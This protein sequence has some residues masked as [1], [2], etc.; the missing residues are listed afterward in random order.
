MSAGYELIGLTASP[1]SMKTRAVMRYRRIPFEWVRDMPQISGRVLKVSP[2]LLPVLC[3]PMGRQ[4]TDSTAIIEVLEREIVNDRRVTHPDPGVAFLSDLIEDMADEWLTKAM[5][6]MRWHDPDGARYAAGAIAAE[7]AP[8]ADA[9][10]RARMAEAVMARQTGRMALVGSTAANAPAVTGSLM[11]IAAALEAHLVQEPFLTGRRPVAA[12]FALYGQFAQL[13]FDTVSAELLRGAAP[14]VG[15]WVRAMEDLSGLEAEWNAP[16]SALAQPVLE[17]LLEECGRVYLPFLVA[18]A[19]AV[20]AGLETV[21]VETPDGGYAGPPSKYQA[22]CLAR[23][24]ERYRTSYI[25]GPAAALLE[26]TGCAEAL[27][28]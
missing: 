9:P 15:Y 14:Q 17:A 24:R 19:A 2:V 25:P 5:F 21:S 18:N 10:D 6:W 16:G 4:M 27:A 28:G 22:K 7:L 1:Y 26:K 8:G 13:C 11:R 23:L 20:D 3:H 12:D